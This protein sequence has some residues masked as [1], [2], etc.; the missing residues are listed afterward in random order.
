M[1]TVVM[2]PTYNEAYNIKKIINDVLNCGIDLN[3]LIVDD[4]SPDGTYKIVEDIAKQNSKVHLLLRKEKKG[5]GY[6]GKDGFIK[7]LD[8]K[9]DFI[10][11]MD[12]DGSHHPKYIQEFLKVIKDCD[13]VIGSR[14]IDNGKDEQRT[15]LRRLISKLS[16]LYL[17]TILDVTIKDPTSGYR[18]YKKEALQKFVS[19]LKANDPFIVTEVIYHIKKN[20]LKVKESPIVFLKRFAGESKLKPAI[21]I[22]YLFK[23]LKL[24]M[25]F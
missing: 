21:L 4:M 5:R 8:M 20:K 18:M 3:V 17:S 15:L 9:A 23:V 24:K 11:E 12:G 19:K 13:V 14:Y 1:K 6:A 16:R 25:S 7:A 2:I 10:V 22:K